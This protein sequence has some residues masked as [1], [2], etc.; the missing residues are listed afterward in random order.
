MSQG[1]RPVDSETSLLYHPDPEN[2]T[3]SD[4]DAP[5]SPDTRRRGTWRFGERRDQD[6]LGN[7]FKLKWWRKKWGDG[8]EQGE[9]R[10]QDRV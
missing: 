7:W 1:N 5:L 9:E 10:I 2:E 3:H 4:T 8:E 6:G